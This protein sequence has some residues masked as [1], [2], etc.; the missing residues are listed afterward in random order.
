MSTKYQNLKK[1]LFG[2]CFCG[3]MYKEDTSGELRYRLTKDG[4][5]CKVN[6]SEHIT[7]LFYY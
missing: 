4:I 7:I 1:L 5:I 2:V 6:Y 3:M